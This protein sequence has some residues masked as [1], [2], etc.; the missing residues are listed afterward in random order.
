MIRIFQLPQEHNQ[1][2]PLYVTF[3]GAEHLQEPIQRPTGLPFFQWF[4]CTKGRGEVILNHERMILSKG[5]GALIYPNTFHAYRGL[6]QDWTLDFLGFTGKAAME[7]LKVL[8]MDNSRLCGIRN[9]V[10][11]SEQIR[12]IIQLEST[13]QSE[14]SLML[15]QRCYTFLT[16]LSQ[17]M[18]QVNE[19]AGY[20]ENPIVE[21]IALYLETH[22]AEPFSLDQLADEMSMTKEYLCH[23][24][25]KE[26]KQTIVQ[27]LTSIRIGRA[28]VLLLQH[29]EKNVFEIGK[30]CGYENSSYFGKV[31]K[32][33]VGTSPDRYR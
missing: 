23:L 24:F 2:L 32:R 20:Y 29:P 22:F 1:I 14:M 3:A 9:P 26:M 11:F 7:I 31:F 15:S 6:T 27:F 4:F 12:A 5:Q 30:M 19:I 33:Y 25:S 10:E 8:Q 13:G 17:S 16:N 18:N 28:R 21:A